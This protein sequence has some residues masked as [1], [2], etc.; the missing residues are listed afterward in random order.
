MRPRCPEWAC[1]VR[2]TATD[3]RVDGA[4]LRRSDTDV[5][6]LPLR[7]SPPRVPDSTR[8]DGYRRLCATSTNA[9]APPKVPANQELLAPIQRQE[10]VDR[11]QEVGGSSPPSSTGSKPLRARGLLS[12]LTRIRAEEPSPIGSCSA[13][14]SNRTDRWPSF[15]P[16]S[17]RFPPK[18]GT[19]ERAAEGQHI[20]RRIPPAQLAPDIESEVH[21]SCSP[22]S[23]RRGAT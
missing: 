23:T 12:F 17:G 15:S 1:A 3:V 2:P 8:I 6:A 13:N 18:R 11:T 22:G 14:R 9:A 19:R 16:C 7:H 10:L 5:A 21:G 4:P 20:P